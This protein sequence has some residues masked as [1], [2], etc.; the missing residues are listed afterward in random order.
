M[1]SIP[2]VPARRGPALEAPG[3][4]NGWL[5]RRGVRMPIWLEA[6]LGRLGSGAALVMGAWIAY[7]VRL[8]RRAIAG[9]MAF[10]GGVRSREVQEGETRGS[11]PPGRPKC[12]WASSTVRGS[13]KARLDG[14]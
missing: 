7:V 9:V 13:T 8:S 3:T 6:G 12:G 2:S 14:L 11:T 5:E 1:P 4:E 10:G